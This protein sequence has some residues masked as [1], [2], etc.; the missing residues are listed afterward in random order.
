MTRI[1]QLTLEQH[2]YLVE[3][4]YVAMPMGDEDYAR[5]QALRQ[6]IQDNDLLEL[7]AK[8]PCSW[9]QHEEGLAPDGANTEILVTRDNFILLAVTSE[10]FDEPFVSSPILHT[11]LDE[12]LAKHREDEDGIAELETPVKRK[13]SQRARLRVL[14]E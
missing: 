14:T 10:D 1:A 6:C 11:E 3:P 13:D 7:R 12:T 8:W 5:L 9:V 2:D 4:E